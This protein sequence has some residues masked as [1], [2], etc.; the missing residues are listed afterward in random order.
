VD[1]SLT[2]ERLVAMLSGFFGGLA[3]LLAGVGVYG[4]TAYAVNR[5][6]AELGVL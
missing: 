2:Q 3:L 1:A 5:R 6:R 4:V